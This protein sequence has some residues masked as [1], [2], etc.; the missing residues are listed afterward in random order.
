MKL[1]GHDLEKSKRS[2][3]YT[4]K[5][6]G[7]RVSVRDLENGRSSMPLYVVK[8]RP[9]T[10]TQGEVLKL[11]DARERF[12]KE[13]RLYHETLKAFLPKGT[14]VWWRHGKHTRCGQVLS[15]S[16]DRVRIQS[17]TYGRK[18]SKYWIDT[19]R[20]TQVLRQEPGERI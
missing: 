6:C 3:H 12:R 19:N 16:G 17:M 18:P 14:S 9:N 4:C 13:T 8:C 15:V 7:W 10:P 1:Y 2:A 11:I 5:E 20:I